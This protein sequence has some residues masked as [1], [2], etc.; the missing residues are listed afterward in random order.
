M[1]TFLPLLL[2]CALLAVLQI[3]ARRP[4]SSV[5]GG[6]ALSLRGGAR[7]SLTSTLMALLKAPNAKKTIKTHT[8]DQPI[9]V[10]GGEEAKPLTAEQLQK[11]EV[12]QKSLLAGQQVTLTIAA[13]ILT[14][15]VYKLDYKN[16]SVLRAARRVF[17]VYL[18]FCH[19]LYALLRL[20]I[21]WVNDKSIVPQVDGF[22]PMTALTRIMG[23][24]PLGALLLRGVQ[25]AKHD[26]HL[27]VS[28]YDAQQNKKLYFGVLQD[29]LMVTFLHGL[30]HKDFYL[31]LIPVM[32]LVSR[33][34]EP[35]VLIHLLRMK[36]VGQL[37]RPF[38]STLQIL[39]DDLIA[40]QAAASATE[41]EEEAHVGPSSQPLVEDEEV[42]V[43]E[44]EVE[45]EAAVEEKELEEDDDLEADKDADAFDYPDQ[46][47]ELFDLIDQLDSILD[48][49][50]R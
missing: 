4:V 15:Y 47:Q 32:G 44:E 25:S 34:K 31:L 11:V 50:K 10:Q 28:Q 12:R 19:L 22:D 45:Q 33:M 6:G 18:V 8:K 41:E 43:L 13:M 39:L 16:P 36:A 46:D 17:V 5:L 49:S 38:K 24:S 2:A 21:A 48:E 9:P 42:E 35:L 14:H 29:I 30:L 40:K 23:P 7:S 3:D 37:S 27:S 1:R 20:R 26:R